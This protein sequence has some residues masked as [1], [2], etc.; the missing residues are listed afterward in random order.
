MWT[1]YCG[2]IALLFIVIKL[3]N[4]RLHRLFDTGEVLEDTSS[5]G[6]GSNGDSDGSSPEETHITQGYV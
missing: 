6:S 4:W 3:V 2:V 1:I 5:N